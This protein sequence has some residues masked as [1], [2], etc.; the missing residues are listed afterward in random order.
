MEITIHTGFLPHDDPDAS[1][2]FYRDALGFEVR[3]DVGQGRTR[4][5]TA[6]PAGRPD[7]SILLAPP[8]S[9]PGTTEDGRRTITR[10][11]ARGTCG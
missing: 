10:V 7:T 3:G 8:A 6:G 1:A 2:A 4:W 9:D 11:M 5:I